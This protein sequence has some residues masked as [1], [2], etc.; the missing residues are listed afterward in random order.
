MKKEL[1]N[2]MLGLALF[3]T[4]FSC[5]LNN[6]LSIVESEKL[7]SVMVSPANGAI[8]SSSVNVKG[9]VMTTVGLKTAQFFFQETNSP[10]IEVVNGNSIGDDVVTVSAQLTLPQKGVYR[11]W[12]KALSL[13]NTVALSEPVYLQ[14]TQFIQTAS[15]ND[16][17]S[18]ASSSEYSSASSQSSSS[19]ATGSDTLPPVVS[20]NPPAGTYTNAVNLILEASDNQDAHPTIFYT[21][22]GT[23]PNQTYNSALALSS[24]TTV[25]VTAVDASGNQSGV[26]QAFYHVVQDTEAPN[27]L[28]GT[29]EGT[30]TNQVSVSL[31]ASDNADNHPIIYYTTNGS[32]PSK[33]SD[34]FSGSITL[35]TNENASRTITVKAIAVDQSGNQSSVLTASYTVVAHEQ[36]VFYFKN[37]SWNSVNAYTWTD[38]SGS[39]TKYSGD[40]PGTNMTQLAN[41][42]YRVVI[43]GISKC[44]IIFSENGAN[45]SADQLDKT[46]GW[47]NGET[48]TW[49]SS[50]P[51]DS[52]PPVVSWIAPS[53]GGTISGTVLLSVSASDD[54][55]V[56]KVVYQINDRVIGESATTPFGFS[57]DSTADISTGS[58]QLTAIAEDGA[59]NRATN[60]LNIYGNNPAIPPV[61]KAGSDQVVVLKN[62]SATAHL[63]ASASYDPDGNIVSYSWSDGSQSASGVSADFVYSSLGTNVVTLTVTDNDGAYSSTT[64]TVIVSDKA[65]LPFFSWDN[66][67]VYFVISDR[68]YNGNPNNDRNYGRKVK[69]EYGSGAIAA[70]T[71][72]GGDIKGLTLKL[73]QGYFTNLGVNAIWITAPY[74][75]IHGWCGGGSANDFPHYAYHGYYPLD[76]TMMDRNMGTI[77]EMREFVETAHAQGIRVIMDIVMNHVG[78]NDLLDAAKYGYGGVTVSEADAANFVSGWD[79]LNSQFQYNNT[80]AW[81]GWWSGSWVRAGDNGSIYN[82]AVDINSDEIKGNTSS[83]PDVKT[84]ETSDV[85]VAPILQ[86]KWS[87]ET[88]AEYTNWINPSAANLRQDLHIAP[89]DYQIKWLAAWVREFGI[90]GFRVDTAKHVDRYRWG[91]LKSACEQAL[92][93]WRND[94][95]KMPN[96]IAKSWT[97]DFWM[98]GEVYGAGYGKADEYAN[99]GFD[100]LI[101]FNFPKDG[102]VNGIGSTW[103]EYAG[104]LNV[105]VGETW[106]TLSYL[107]SHDK[108]L[109]DRGNMINEGTTLLLS[110]GAVQIFYGDE[111]ARP[112]GDG[113]STSDSMQGSRSDYVW[114]DHPEVL[115]HW[116]KLGTFRNRH[117]AVGAGTQDDL[118]NNFYG[119]QYS[120][121]GVTDKVII[122]VAQSGTVTVN[123]SSYFSDGTLLR[124]AYTGDTATVSG[125]SVSFSV[126]ANGVVLIEEAN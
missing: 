36:L 10:T 67:E 79:Y 98:T 87:M 124:D 95:S 93:D 8:E 108:G 30:Y 85:G 81:D 18:S 69:D 101:N 27:L 105:T 77:A 12:L 119:R 51:D 21:T 66:A 35:Q 4:L 112:W 102:N 68:F 92:S 58:Y 116:Q 34:V 46:G 32:T 65:D 80:S 1:R 106:N 114:G 14:V 24:D 115:T 96:D 39:A 7:V 125:G 76:W 63:N 120:K 11:I 61:A 113:S 9:Q 100:S 55:Q 41:G 2:L 23:V 103:A 5:R 97:N 31:S 72:H 3:T 26:T 62:G 37:T 42:W 84:E 64:V 33:Q 83:L 74:E 44:N 59:G 19:S 75:Q 109:S 43:D 28:L 48:D 53:E 15:T 20:F 29:Y 122:G 70:G 50:D 107:S 45:Q 16:S 17:S 111:N 126:G 94:S 104:Y 22:N 60:T 118:G 52:T 57:W 90:D 78:Y 6:E 110:P 13:S 123:V 54:N 25:Y 82:N 88:S 47:Y 71:F 40:W 56:S 73:Q 38:V 86:T 121:G 89:A 99:N 91:Q 49:T 117:V